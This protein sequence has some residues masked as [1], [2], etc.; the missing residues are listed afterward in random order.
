[1]M[2]ILITDGAGFIDFELGK[3]LIMQEFNCIS[4]GFWR[5]DVLC[6]H[7]LNINMLLRLLLIYARRCK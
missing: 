6:P 7:W 2:K 3:F 1:M 5:L 4:T